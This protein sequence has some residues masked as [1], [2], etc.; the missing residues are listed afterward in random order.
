MRLHFY[1]FAFILVFWS[2]H[3]WNDCWINILLHAENIF[4]QSIIFLS[5]ACENTRKGRKQNKV[6]ESKNVH[7]CV[8]CRD[9]QHISLMGTEAYRNLLLCFLKQ[10][11][12]N[13]YNFFGNG[14]HSYLTFKGVCGAAWSVAFHQ[15]NG[16]FSHLSVYASVRSIPTS[17]LPLTKTRVDTFGKLNQIGIL[18]KMSWFSFNLS[19]RTAA[20][21]PVIE[22]L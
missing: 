16:S 2:N 17:C 1:L 12:W 11:V 7:V 10:A 15:E 21:C 18:N 14:K 9:Q 20:F 19:G 22:F 13:V 8:P 3:D 4:M 5:L 6:I